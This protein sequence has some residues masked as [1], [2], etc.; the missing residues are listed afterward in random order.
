MNPDVDQGA[1]DIIDLI[2]RRLPWL[3]EDAWG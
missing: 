1:R 2:A 3:P